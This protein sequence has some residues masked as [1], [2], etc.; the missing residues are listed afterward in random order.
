MGNIQRGDQ[1]QYFQQVAGQTNIGDMA[2]L[3]NQ[4]LNTGVSTVQKANESNLANN[5]I[6]LSTKFLAKNNEI[7]TKYQADPTNPEREVELQEAFEELASSYDINPVCQGQW[8]TI[9]N[10]VYNRYKTHNAE[11]VEKQQNTNIETN[12]KNGY[13]S[14]AN[15]ISMLGLNG[16]SVDDMRLIYANG[17]EGLKTTATARLGS[18]VV[19]NFLKDADHDFMTTY[20]SALALNNPLEAQ[21][22][23][24]DEG[25][26]NDIGRAET[27]EKLENYVASSLSNQQ[28]RTAVAELGS[29]LRS[30]NSQEADDILNGK[31]D[32]NKVMK[33]IE[34]NKNLPEG[35]KDLVLGIYGIGSRSEYVYDRDKKRIVKK[36]EAGSGSKSSSGIKLTPELKIYTA[37]VLEND[38]HDLLEFSAS[39]EG[40]QNVKTVKKNK[41]QQEAQ[42]SV[43]GYMQRVAGMQARIDTAYNA[44]AIGKDE[45]KRLMNTYISP[46]VDYLEA[47]LEQL[48]EG[49][50]MGSKLGY[51]K[52][53]KQFS[54]DGLKKQ[55]DI[56]AV[57]RQKLFAQNYYLDELHKV[58]QGSKGALKSV[59]DIESLPSSQQREIYQ[60]ASENA[61]KRAKR[62]TDKPEYFFAKEFPDIYSQPFVMFKQDKALE[63]NR[64]VAEAVY[65]REFENL[66]GS[67]NLDLKD[68]ANTRMYEETIK[69]VKINRIRANG[70]L[71]PQEQ[72][73]VLTAPDPKSYQELEGKLKEMGFTIKDFHE[74]A[75]EN[76]YVEPNNNNQWRQ[77]G[78]LNQWYMRAYRDLRYAKALKDRNKK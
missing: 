41:S 59:Y 27:L 74:F 24:Q 68:F 61:L 22:L 53:K 46:V 9:K 31:A 23:L 21:R 8:N 40:V 4:A 72:G 29:V 55:E 73:Q 37:E 32:L 7:N 28:K 43:I 14:L 33:F 10:N 11:W 2:Q 50:F 63:I 71:F 70:T 49:R 1:R 75:V 60:L 47:N 15:Q 17:I 58:V 45:R 12:L 35:S 67:S 44:G 77:G 34:T 76:G 42:N 51:D 20:I 39:G 6:D 52:I 48:D 26:R 57:N 69:Q 62:W 36:E 78:Y 25:V 54:T 13:E 56:R 3:A 66:D 64:N 30:M 65:K 19:D 18:V 38:L 16:S 5:Q